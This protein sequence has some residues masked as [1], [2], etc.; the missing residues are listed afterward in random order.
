MGKRILCLF[1]ALTCIPLFAGSVSDADVILNQTNRRAGICSM[2]RCSDGDLAVALIENSDLTIHVMH[3]DPEQV[4]KLQDLAKSKGYLGIRMYV[5][6]GEM[7]TSPLAD[8]LCDLVVI[9]DLKQSDLTEELAKDINRTL[10]PYR[11]IVLLSGVETASLETF[12]KLL[13]GYESSAFVVPRSSVAS[14]VLA[15]KPALKGADEWTHFMHGADNNP[16]ST[17]QVVKK[18][19]NIQYITPP[20]VS[21]GGSSR[22]AN[23]RFIE[24]QG[25]QHKHGPTGS[26]DGLIWCRN[27]YNGQLLWSFKLEQ[28]IEAKQPSVVVIGDT[29]YTVGGGKPEVW[30]YDAET[31]KQLDPISF[32]IDKSQVKWLAIDDGILFVLMGRVAPE[33]APG[34]TYHGRNP[35]RDE[36]VKNKLNHGTAVLAYDLDAGRILWKYEEEKNLIDNREIGAGYGRVV[37]LTEDPAREMKGSDEIVKGKAVIALDSG[38]G[39]ILWKNEDEHLAT[40][41]R[42]YQFIFGREYHPGLIVGPEAIRMRLI[43]IY[44]NDLFMIDA[45]TGKTNWTILTDPK[46]KKSGAGSFSGFFAE[47]GYVHSKTVF[48]TETGKRIKQL[49]QWDGGCGVRTWSPAG[50]FGNGNGSSIGMDVKSDCHMGSFAAGGLVHVPR[51][52]CHCKTVWRGTFAFAPRGDLDVHAKAE[53]KRLIEGEAFNECGL[54]NA[55]CGMKDWVTYRHDSNR[56]AGTPVSIPLD[57]KLLWTNQPKHSYTFSKAYGKYQ[58]A[59]QDQPTEPVAAYGMV[60]HS[61]TDGKVEAVDAETGKTAWTYWT[62]GRVYAAPTIWK[63]RV[64]IGG[65]D[66]YVYCIDA[67]SGKLAWKFRAAPFDQRIMNAMRL[68]S[69]WPVLT[70]VLIHDGFAYFA[71]GLEN[72]MGVHVYALDAA[73]GEQKWYVSDAGNGGGQELESP[74]TPDGF[75]TV[76][77]NN[78]YIQNRLEIEAR[79]DLKTGKKLERPDYPRPRKRMGFSILGNL[80]REIINLGNGWIMTG[81]RYLQHELNQRE[82]DRGHPAFWMKK[83]DEY[84][85]LICRAKVRFTAESILPP[86]YDE[87]GMALVPGGFGRHYIMVKGKKVRTQ[88][89]K[90]TGTLGL[91]MI[92]TSSI[93]SL[94]DKAAELAKDYGKDEGAQYKPLKELTL[95]SDNNE[96]AK[97]APTF[98]EMFR[99]SDGFKWQF[100]EQWVQVNGVV[101]AKNAAVF[102]RGYVDQEVRRERLEFK[103][104]SVIACERETGKIIWEHELP[105]EPMLNGLCIDRDGR[106]I[107]TLRDGSVTAVGSK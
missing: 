107:V 14:G 72:S 19:F 105:E 103:K 46:N 98:P 42:R 60:F 97:K 12:C 38:S 6:Q 27:A 75:M 100:E 81:G 73:T 88:S 5:E 8:W 47:G 13:K 32:G 16:V 48:N 96:E 35:A 87:N 26:L 56:S 91:Q 94:A 21:A 20:T 9:T 53:G 29:I 10:S 70:G 82:G 31:G 50:I 52:W 25:Q 49:D 36:I 106:V 18:P 22:F 1:L 92:D 99:K 15:R 69:R 64:Y 3:S 11:G 84:G 58:M 62:A 80:G 37:F 43:G 83:F 68:E 33:F 30:R 74:F 90:P 7:T 24:M 85:N 101:L 39:R 44:G 71:A 78:L 104:W 95:K 45:E 77:G 93:V 17:D 86:A 2:P 23:G 4:K 40:L 63:G 67:Q 59:R 55:D 57:T 61:G 41:K 34:T 102:T 28:H 54:R 89:P 51:G 79:F 76:Y 65:C 66:G